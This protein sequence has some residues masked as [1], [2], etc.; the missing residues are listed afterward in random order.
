[1][2]S[3]VVAWVVGGA[4]LASVGACIALRD[5]LQGKVPEA[6]LSKAAPAG[7][8][9]P[10]G[11]DA[12]GTR[13]HAR[14]AQ[15]GQWLSLAASTVSLA[16]Y[17]RPVGRWFESWTVPGAAWIV[18]LVGA[19]LTAMWALDG[20][21][22]S[23]NPQRD[24]RSRT[25]G[26]LRANHLYAGACLLLVVVPWFFQ[27]PQ[28][29]GADLDDF[30]NYYQPTMASFLS[31]LGVALY[32]PLTCFTLC[33]ITWT[34]ARF[35]TDQAVRA[36]LRLIAVGA[37]AGLSVVAVQLV[38]GLSWT[39][40]DP[41]WSEGQAAAW[42][43]VCVV[44]T[45]ALVTVGCLWAPATHAHRER[46]ARFLVP[47]WRDDV[48][49]LRPMWRLLDRATGTAYEADVVTAANVEELRTQ[50]RR[51]VMAMW[52]A[53]VILQDH[54]TPAARQDVQNSLGPVRVHLRHRLLRALGEVAVPWLR[55][56]GGF[57]PERAQQWWRV[58]TETPLA[59]Y[60][61]LD[62]ACARTA[63]TWRLVQG[64]PSD[65]DVRRGKLDGTH[66]RRQHAVIWST[67]PRSE[68]EMV[69]YFRLL[70][71]VAATRPVG[72]AARRAFFHMI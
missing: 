17:C 49:T 1:M 45:S 64:G 28:P 42:Q 38:Q 58:L 44:V 46:S 10:T 16:L 59:P 20:L 15:R 9:W 61:R 23:V 36:S 41:L 48:D 50:R 5:L 54:L 67:T 40:G 62:A 6:Q 18:A 13:V 29:R 4:A 19:V 32:Y 2:F 25:T 68:D 52:D 55:L 7:L 3:D 65:E 43:L 31:V 21:I 70:A 26:L 35:E 63:T 14:R 22:W 53:L 27:P 8:L 60:A 56:T 39:R 57:N 72:D 12:T 34:A 66:L 37:M 69:A 11:L 71:N 24:G 51:M 33:R 30:M 47:L